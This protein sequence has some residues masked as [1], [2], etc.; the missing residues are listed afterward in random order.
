[1]KTSGLRTTMKPTRVF[2]S[3]QPVGYRRPAGADPFTYQD[4]RPSRW[5]ASWWTR[6]HSTELYRSK[7]V[8]TRDEAVRIAH[9]FLERENKA[10]VRWIDTTNQPQ[11]YGYAHTPELTEK[12]SPAQLDVEIDEALA[13]EKES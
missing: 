6:G 1:M 12:K 4:K 2:L 11:R 5:R 7:I 3:V 9:K 10:G 8:A 13:K